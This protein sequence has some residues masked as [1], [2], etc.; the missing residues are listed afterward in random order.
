MQQLEMHLEAML[1]TYQLNQEKLSYNVQLLTQRNAES[2]AALVQHRTRQNHCREALTKIAAKFREVRK[3]YL[4]AVF[5]LELSSVSRTA[6]CYGF[7]QLML[8]PAA[9]S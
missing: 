9:L 4:W 2:A 8:A 3:R 6:G 5:P 7:L 1:A